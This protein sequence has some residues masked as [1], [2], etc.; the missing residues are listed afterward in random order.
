MTVS[1]VRFAPALQLRN[2]C[3]CMDCRRPVPTKS[4]DMG[5]EGHSCVLTHG[6]PS[7][8]ASSTS[9]KRSLSRGMS[10][11]RRTH[12]PCQSMPSCKPCSTQCLLQRSPEWS[13]CCKFEHQLVPR[14]HRRSEKLPG[15]DSGLDSGVGFLC[16]ELCGWIEVWFWVWISGRISGW[17][18][19]DRFLSGFLGAGWMDGWMVAWMVGWMDGWGLIS[20]GWMDVIVCGW[21]GFWEDF[22][23][24]FW[25]DWRISGALSWGM[26]SEAD[27]CVYWVAGFCEFRC[28]FPG[29]FR[30]GFPDGF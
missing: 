25:V 9:G 22:W 24:D 23:V 1:E 19:G 20:V 18:S 13:R 29:E 16:L 5:N 6:A 30:G 21:M 2:G 28:E 26:I 12:R 27:F 14:Q 8:S 3:R 17:S 10:T 7:C 4:A 11:P 15:L